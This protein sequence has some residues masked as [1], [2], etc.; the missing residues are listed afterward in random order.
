MGSTLNMGKSFTAEHHVMYQY[1][2]LN[3]RNHY[4]TLIQ[5]ETPYFQP[6][7]LAIPAPFKTMTNYGDPHFP[8][9]ISM[10]WA[11]IVK[12]SSDILVFGAGLYSFYNN[13]SQACLA[14]RNCQGHI[15]NIIDSAVDI[16]SLVTIG[17]QFQVSV[18]GRG[19]VDQKDNMNGFASTV[20]VWRSE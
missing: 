17:S 14:T 5:T 6:G 19:V 10:A 11:V 12:S 4:M 8:P 13:Y 16:F 1:Q 2:F 3:A 18:N 7:S 20:T 15:L 9:G